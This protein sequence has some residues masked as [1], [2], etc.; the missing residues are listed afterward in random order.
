MTSA[1]ARLLLFPIDIQNQMPAWLASH[2]IAAGT[3]ED[4]EDRRI[5][6]FWPLA[7]DMNERTLPQELDR[8]QR[9]ISF[10]KGCYLGQET[11]ARL[12]AMGEVQKKLCLVQLDGSTEMAAGQS[13]MRDDKEVG[14]LSSVSPVP[15]AGKRFALAT[16]R[17]GSISPGSQ[18]MIAEPTDATIATGS[19]TVIAHP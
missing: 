13:L 2:G 15:P 17:R 16:M 12:D 8:D 9:A 3:A 10:T 4:L 5:R 19:G 11:V 18:F 14:K 6:N 7:C 1:D